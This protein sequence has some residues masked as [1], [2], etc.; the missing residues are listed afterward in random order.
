MPIPV[1]PLGAFL[2]FMCFWGSN[3][4]FATNGYFPHGVGTSNKAMA[5]A[6]MALPEL[7]FSS[8]IAKK[9]PSKP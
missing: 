9:N 3:V 7:G 6:G 5:G 4:C 2:V 8:C 1:L